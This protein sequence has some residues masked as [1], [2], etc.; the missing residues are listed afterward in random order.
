LRHDADVSTANRED[1]VAEL[2]RW[3]KAIAPTA[4]DGLAA[5]WFGLTELMV[6]GEPRATLYVAGTERF[7]PD[8]NTGDWAA[9]D[10]AWW[11]DDRYTSPAGLAAI[12]D[13][14]PQA[15][16]N[17]AADL[18]RAIRPHEDVKVQ[19]VAVGFDDGDFTVLWRAP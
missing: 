1:D 9:G 2:S 13:S 8:D 12:S 3:W 11:P 17:Y 6:E 19:G 14:E 15:Q 4:P 10:Y 5:L 18:V 16:L 7:D